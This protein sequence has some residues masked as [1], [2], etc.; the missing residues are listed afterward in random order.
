M[1]DGDP[2]F[3]VVQGDNA[4]VLATL[5]E[6]NDHKM[7]L[8]DFRSAVLHWAT[9]LKGSSGPRR[10]GSYRKGQGTSFR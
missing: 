4:T 3:S 1:A 2:R 5:G 10:F 7:T 9:A 8:I 6:R